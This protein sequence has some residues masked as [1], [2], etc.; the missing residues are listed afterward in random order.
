MTK[1]LL[2]FSLIA[3]FPRQKYLYHE[4]LR[5]KVVDTTSG[6]S[7]LF[8]KHIQGKK[9]FN[10]WFYLPFAEG[11]TF[12]KGTRFTIL[13]YPYS[14][15]SKSHREARYLSITENQVKET[16]KYCLVSSGIGIC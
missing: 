8:Y 13:T 15:S 11:I 5:L 3:P 14:D 12:G 7:T 16:Q 9:Q 10:S 6:L 4:N 1:Y 2:S